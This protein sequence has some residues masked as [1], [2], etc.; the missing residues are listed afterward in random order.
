MKSLLLNI[1]TIHKELNDKINIIIEKEIKVK[2]LKNKIFK[3]K[4]FIEKK[5]KIFLNN[6]ELKDEDYIK[7]NYI[8]QFDIILCTII[9]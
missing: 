5:K 1:I 7:P 2:N 6:F 9:E 8:T 4:G 3:L